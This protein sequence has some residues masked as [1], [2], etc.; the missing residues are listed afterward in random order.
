MARAGRGRIVNIASTSD[1]RAGPGRSAYGA[2]KAA[3]IALTRQMVAE[4]APPGHHRELQTWLAFTP[5]SRAT[6][7]TDAPDR[8]NAL[9]ISHL[10]AT[11]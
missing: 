2:S 10:R 5:Y 6:R 3:L 11:G 9:I 4:L 7:A 1:V 8:N